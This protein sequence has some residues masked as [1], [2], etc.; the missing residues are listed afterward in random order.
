MNDIDLAQLF[1]ETKSIKDGALTIPGYTPDGWGV[2]IFTESGLV[3][4]DKPIKDFTAERAAR[5]PLQG[6]DEG[7]GQRTST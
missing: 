2:R 1:D 5:L 6:G 3:P 4:G 7:Q